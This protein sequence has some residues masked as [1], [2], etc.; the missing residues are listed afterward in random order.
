MCKR[1]C[2]VIE[3]NRAAR[4]VLS[5]AFAG[6]LSAYLSLTQLDGGSGCASPESRL[7]TPFLTRARFER[8]QVECKRS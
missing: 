7:L 2:T 6:S 4:P 3:G 1:T 5:S 8:D